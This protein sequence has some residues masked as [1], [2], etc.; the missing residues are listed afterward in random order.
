VLAQSSWGISVK[1]MA[2]ALSMHFTLPDL[3]LLD[4]LFPYYPLYG[5]HKSAG[6]SSAI[7]CSGG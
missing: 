1:K 3:L 5:Y 4:S 6:N 2:V 7:N